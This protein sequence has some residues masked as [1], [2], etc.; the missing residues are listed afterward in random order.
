MVVAAAVV[1][2]AV[3]VGFV[4]VEMRHAADLEQSL[5]APVGAVVVSDHQGHHMIGVVLIHNTVRSNTYL[6]QDAD[7]SR[8]QVWCD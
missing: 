5:A 6:G 8:L 4:P 2:A 3:V 7:H 1:I